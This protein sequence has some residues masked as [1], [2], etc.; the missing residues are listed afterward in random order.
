MSIKI[1]DQYRHSPRYEH[2]FNVFCERLEKHFNDIP[3]F[4]PDTV[5]DTVLEKKNEKRRYRT[6]LVKE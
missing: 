1:D 2:H 5:F 6:T 4:D 3:V